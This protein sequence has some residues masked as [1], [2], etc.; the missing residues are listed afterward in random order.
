[1]SGVIHD[2]FQSV[3]GTIALLGAAM[4]AVSVAGVAVK[5]GLRWLDHAMLSSDYLSER[6]G[7]R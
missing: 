3:L 7:P 4:V 1:M 5:L 6:G 2:A